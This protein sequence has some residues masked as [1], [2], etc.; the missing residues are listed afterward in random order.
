METLTQ[1]H[2][3]THQGCFLREGDGRREGEGSRGRGL[4]PPLDSKLG[5]PCMITW[6]RNKGLLFILMVPESRPLK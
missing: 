1:A 5:I 3:F 4:V 6:C 2:V